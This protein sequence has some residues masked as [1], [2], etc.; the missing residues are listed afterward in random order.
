MVQATARLTAEFGP[1]GVQQIKQSELSHLDR[2]LVFVRLLIRV[3]GEE[4]PRGASVLGG[5][6][7]PPPQGNW[8]VREAERECRQ[9][10]IDRI[11]VLLQV[12]I[13]IEVHNRIVIATYSIKLNI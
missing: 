8:T 2:V 1:R 7:L 6:E 3:L 13:I 12:P 5:I 10:V 9:R 4:I 11:I